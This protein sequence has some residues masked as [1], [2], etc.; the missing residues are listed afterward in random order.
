MS[1]KMN[2]KLLRFAVFLAKMPSDRYRE[3]KKRLDS[4]KKNIYINRK[5]E[6]RA[7]RKMQLKKKKIRIFTV[8]KKFVLK[9]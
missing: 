5:K 4:Y 2:E 7:I 9:G 8:C 3:K 6:E 1:L